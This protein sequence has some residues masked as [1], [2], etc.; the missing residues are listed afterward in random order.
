MGNTSIE[1]TDATWNPVTGCTKVSPGCKLCYAERVFP[2]TAAGQLTYVDGRPVLQE[3]VDAGLVFESEVRQRNFTD[4]RTHPDRLEQPL[5]WKKPRKIFVNSMSDLFHEDVPFEFIDRAF[6]VMA[7]T[8]QHTYQILTKRPERMLEYFKSWDRWTWP[9]GDPPNFGPRVATAC[10]SIGFSLGMAAEAFHLMQHIF[11]KPLQN[12]WLGVSVEN[13][14]YADE[15]IQILLQTPAAVRF[16]SYE[17]ALGPVDFTKITHRL[18]PN[19]FE[20]FNSLYEKDSL[21][22]GRPRPRLDWVIVG[23]ESGPGARPFN[24]NWARS[25]IRQCRDANVAC[26]VKQ[27]GAKPYACRESSNGK[28][29][30]ASCISEGLEDVSDRKGGLIAELPEDVR[31]RAFPEVK[32]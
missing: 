14:L 24:L 30:H 4:V 20:T 23:G 31:V 6:A 8:P 21:N 32:S 26:F 28:P 7:L 9:D 27:V 25:V 29:D 15:R 1:W 12:V 10:G 17:P 13:Q 2:R 18:G 3:L 16:V 5:H 11:Q 22:K 19:S